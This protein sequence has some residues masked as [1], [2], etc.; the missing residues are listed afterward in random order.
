MTFILRYPRNNMGE[1]IL[2]YLRHKRVHP[3]D[4]I[5]RNVIVH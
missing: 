1:S 5:E 2:K 3:E 4:Q